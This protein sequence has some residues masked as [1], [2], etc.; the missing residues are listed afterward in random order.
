MSTAAARDEEYEDFLRWRAAT[1]Q[2]RA[3]I[4][5]MLPEMES[6]NAIELSDVVGASETGAA[7]SCEGVEGAVLGLTAGAATEAAGVEQVV[8]KKEYGVPQDLTFWQLWLI[9]LSFGCRAWGGPTVQIDMMRQEMCEERKWLEPAKFNRVYGI[10]QVLPG[11]EATELACYFGLCAKGRLGSLVGG[12]GF[13]AP[14]FVLMLVLS[15]ITFDYGADSVWFRACVAG[16]VPAVVALV[17][18]GTEKIAQHFLLSNNDPSSKVPLLERWYNLW[19]FA[20]VVFTCVQA[21]VRI[22][23]FI[24]IGVGAVLAVLAFSPWPWLPRVS[25]LILRTVVRLLP[26]L[27]WIAACIG[28]F[29]AYVAVTGGLPTAN[30]VIGVASEPSYS[31]LFVLG[32]LAGLLTFGGA[33]TAIP[34]VYSAAVLNGQWLSEAQFLTALALG[35]IIPA[36]L[37][38]FVMYVGFVGA[39]W[40]GAVLITLGMFIPAFSFTLVIHAVIDPLFKLQWVLNALDGV[41]TAVVGLLAVTAFS[42]LFQ[43]VVDTYSTALLVLALAAAYYFNHKLLVPMIIITAVIAGLVGYSPAFVVVAANSTAA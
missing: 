1:W 29:A 40:G 22:N 18:R 12:A 27:L 15:W 33:A 38:I 21:V 14:G 13:V 5:P 11:P 31:S 20:M 7:T 32:L 36:P 17:F 23:F 6:T 25:N 4:Q 24:S 28:G 41:T 34:F 35:S 30:F 9:F 2:Q 19:L 42:L 43:A 37:V 26:P 39:R 3:S 16:V 10:Y 8:A